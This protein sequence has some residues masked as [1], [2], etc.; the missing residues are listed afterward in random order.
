[1][2]RG[3]SII[4]SAE[5]RGVFDEGTIGDTSLPGTLMQLQAAVA[6][7]N[8]RYSY[9]AFAP[10]TDGKSG[11]CAVLREDIMQGKKISDAYVSGTRCFL[12]YPIAGE[13]VNLRL[14]EVAGTGNTYAIGDR[15]IADAEDGILVPE[16]GTPQELVAV[17]LETTTQQA[18]G[19]LVMCKWAK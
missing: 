17:V 15:L 7:V 8:G 5:P 4:V 16:A 19:V 11:I 3:Q 9:V 6:P 12:Y 10:G 2:S 14:G 13:E 1:M 18:G